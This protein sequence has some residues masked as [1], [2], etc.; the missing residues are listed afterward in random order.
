VQVPVSD[1]ATLEE[2]EAD[3]YPIYQRLRSEQPISR[4]KALDRIVVTTWDPAMEVYR[5]EEDFGPPPHLDPF[6]GVPNILSMT[7]PEHTSLRVG[8][9][10]QLRP[11]VVNGY[12]EELV[13]PICR[14]YIERIVDQGAADL[15]TE[16]LEPISVRAV[17]DV[18]GLDDLDDAT[19]VRWFHGLARGMVESDEF[20]E[21]TATA[22]AELDAY[23]L[24]R[25]ERLASQPDGSML[26]HMVHGG[27]DEGDPRGFDDLIGSI[28]VIILGGLQEPGHGAANA[29]MGVLADPEQ[30]AQIAADP[31]ALAGPAVHEGLRWMAP[32][33]LLAR[34]ALKDTTLAGLELA[35][36]DV[37]TLSLASANRDED[38]YA[39]P[40]RFDLHRARQQHLAFGFG[41]HVC[42]GH[43]LSRQLDQ[44]ALEELFT[45]LP[46]LRLDPDKE[47]TVWGFTFR[48]ALSLP[49]VW[50]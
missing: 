28:R 6:F 49:V 3:P 20:A 43:F 36:G 9:D 18:L 44:I 37:V 48:G 42:S 10:A 25:L 23:M 11:K 26:S 47:P 30:A 32:I 2:L 34:V 41:S 21:Q 50:N 7:G 22:K 12:L 35:E 1:V 15:T 8:V 38:R 5:R 33:Q 40:E 16:L 45:A 29:V 19:L 4:I 14:R 13:R 24:E 31:H 39:D 17:G 46:G 27:R